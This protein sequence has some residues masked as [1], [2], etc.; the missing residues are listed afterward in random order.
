MFVS[1]ADIPG[2]IEGAH[3][4][5]GLGFAFLRH[6]ERCLCLLYVIDLSLDE[7]WAQLDCLKYELEQYQEGLSERPYAVI[8]NKMDLPEAAANFKELQKRV[9]IPVI[10]ISAENKLN[11]QELLVHLRSLYD[12]HKSD[13]L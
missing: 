8:G 2:L 4:N 6:I 5:K 3:Q 9:N 10:P 1:V 7:P 11:I 13:I 12:L